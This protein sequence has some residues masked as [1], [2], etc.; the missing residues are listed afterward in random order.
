[1][2]VGGST[3]FVCK[4]YQASIKVFVMLMFE[5]KHYHIKQ[6]KHILYTYRLRDRLERSTS[7]E[8]GNKLQMGAGGPEANSY[9][10][11]G[12]Q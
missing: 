10:F 11:A 12:S 6:E 7:L 8:K 3:V 5:H 2:Q 1:M 4:T 9:F